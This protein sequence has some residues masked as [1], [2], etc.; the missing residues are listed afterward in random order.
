MLDTYNP[1]AHHSSSQWKKH[2]N[3][4]QVIETHNKELYNRLKKAVRTMIR[5][6][7]KVKHFKI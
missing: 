5:N 3:E 2:Q 6:K 4:L 7:N 1:N